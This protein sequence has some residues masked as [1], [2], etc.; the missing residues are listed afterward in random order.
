MIRLTSLPERSLRMI[1]YYGYK[2]GIRLLEADDKKMIV[3]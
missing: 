1:G 2:N 3:R